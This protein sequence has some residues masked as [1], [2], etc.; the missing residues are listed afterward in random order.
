MNKSTDIKKI[1]QVCKKE[2][3]VQI[4]EHP[5]SCDDRRKS[6]ISCPYCKNVIENIILDKNQDISERKI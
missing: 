6:Y 1:C 2:F 3:I 4:I 5:C